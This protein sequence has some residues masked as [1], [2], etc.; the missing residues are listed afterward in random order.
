MT[1]SVAAPYTISAFGAGE[2]DKAVDNA[3]MRREGR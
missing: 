1:T 3:V 2:L